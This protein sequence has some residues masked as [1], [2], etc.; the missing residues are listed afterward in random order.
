MAAAAAPNDDLN[1]AN[2]GVDPPAPLPAIQQLQANAAEL[3]NRDRLPFVG[4]I[5]RSKLNRAYTLKSILGEGGMYI[6]CFRIALF[7]SKSCLQ[8]M[9]QFLKRR[10]LLIG[11]QTPVF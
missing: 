11:R 2:I 4:D 9:E 10:I 8:A 7:I 5:I 1:G 3:N 6:N